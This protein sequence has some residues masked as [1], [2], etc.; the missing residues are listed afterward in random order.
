VTFVGHLAGPAEVQPVLD[1]AD[2][3]VHPSMTEGLP[4]VV[5]EAM[6]RGKPCIATDV[7]GTSELLGPSALVV[8][9]DVGAMTAAI[10]RVAADPIWRRDQASR[11]LTRA[12]DFA[13]TELDQRR[14]RFYQG[15][16]A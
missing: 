8:A 2:L 10:G 3:V 1:R 16:S 9:G 4:R 13:A 7:G 14:K 15:I 6:A 5:L 11:N 12:R